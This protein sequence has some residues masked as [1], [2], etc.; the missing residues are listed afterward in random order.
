MNLH[1]L[2]WGQFFE[3][4][5]H[6]WREQGCIPARVSEEH[7]TRYM[8]IGEFGTLPAE[9]SGRFRHQA[10]TPDRFPAV[11]DWAAVTPTAEKD[12]CIIHGLLE[13]KS[14]FSRK[15]ASSGGMPDSGGRTDEQILAANIDTVFLV[16]GLDGDF[17]AK[18]VE[19]YLVAAWDSGATPVI[20]LNKA[21]ICDNIDERVDE[22]SSVAFGVPVLVISA[23]EN[24]GMEALDPYLDA[25]QTTVFLGSSGV[26]KSTIINRLL[27]EERIKTQ[28][29]REY[30][31]RGRHTT[32]FR[33]MMFLPGGGIVIDTPGMRE[34]QLWDD[35]GLSKAFADVEELTGQ[36]RFN[37]CRHE[38]EPGCAV[39]EAIRDGRLSEDRYRRYLKLQKENRFLAMRKDQAAQRRAVRE[40][41]R[42][43]RQY[44]QAKKDL[45]KRGLL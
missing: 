20:L 33:Q 31:S 22:I 4:Q 14:G 5:F 3:G 42:R 13:R 27:G 24:R 15:A 32:T 16:S 43:I 21:D 40:W 23:Q 34:L 7:R 29:V 35:G 38:S 18:R 17:N 30:D 36:C 2:G 37:D 26:G 39:L 1:T 25:A 10:E 8:V 41:D 28:A 12:R 45:K 44:N 19:R 11:G 6:A 9:V